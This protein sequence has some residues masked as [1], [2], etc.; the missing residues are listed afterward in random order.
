MHCSA[1]ENQ[2]CTLTVIFGVE[3]LKSIKV[4]QNLLLKSLQL[5]TRVENVGFLSWRT[6]SVGKYGIQN[7]NF[8][9]DRNF[10]RVFDFPPLDLKR[11]RYCRS[12]D[13]RMGKQNALLFWAI[14]NSPDQSL[15]AT[16]TVKFSFQRRKMSTHALQKM[17]SDL[18]RAMSLAPRQ[19][20]PRN[21]VEI[22]E[23]MAAFFWQWQ[24]CN[25][26][27]L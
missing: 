14:N 24:R 23:A 8:E 2:T 13:A 6:F 22:K 21:V 3:S 4:Q 15:T 25:F 16:P 18:F 12:A 1:S 5:K 19:K 26:L 20:Y 7:N 17:T 9:K 10:M 27:P 11:P